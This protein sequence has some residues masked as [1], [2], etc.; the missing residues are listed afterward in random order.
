MNPEY[1]ISIYLDK[2]REKASGKYPV[3]LRVFT[4]YPRRQKF[5]KTPY[6]YSI[7]DFNKIWESKTPRS[8][9]HKQ[10]K[11]KLQGVLNNAEMI[12]ESLQSFDFSS[13]DKKYAGK[14][15][16]QLTAL[17]FLYNQAIDKYKNNGNVKTAS[18]YDSSLKSLLS[19]HKKDS[20]SLFDINPSWLVGYEKHLIDDLK[21]SKS[22]VGIYLRPLRAIYNQAIEDGIISR[23]RYPFG[24][25]KYVIPA[26]KAVKKAL[27]KEQIMILFNS[28]PETAEQAK[29]KA[30]W[31]FSYLCNGMNMKDIL[32]LQ[33]K[34]I[35]DDTITFR[36][37]KTENTN[38]NQIPV[39]VYPH[40]Y[41][42]KMI[43]EYSNEEQ[44]P[45]SHLFPILD[46]SMNAEE[47]TR[48][49]SNFIRYINQHFKKFAVA[50]G[51]TED[52]STYWA[53]HS[54]ATIAIQE[55]ATMEMVS[56]AL[57]HTNLTTTKNYF[58]GFEPKHKKKMSNSLL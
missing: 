23:D 3:R 14:K 18:N 44:F 55:G 50:L 58:A 38:R 11:L 24:K 13:F 9:A 49:I 1:H 7:E 46:S 52:V 51:I 45:E 12:A 17:D 10:E 19:F 26:P 20:L 33:F 8:R 27:S 22:T 31:F 28:E 36:R 42:W 32:N 29:A 57:A 5:Y 35:A 41:V 2:R 21:R 54:F 6:S 47:Q 30:F 43:N 39:V 25:G 48:K 37:K 15:A 40:E 34:D 56:E 4:P 16:G 53:R